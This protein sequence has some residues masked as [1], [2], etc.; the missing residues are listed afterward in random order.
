MAKFAFEFAGSRNIVETAGL[1]P[2]LLAETLGDLNRQMTKYAVDL[3]LQ[4]AATGLPGII[5]DNTP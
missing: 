3:P 5:P 2:H 4:I 1:D